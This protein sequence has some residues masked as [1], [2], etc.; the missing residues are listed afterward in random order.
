[1]APTKGTVVSAA[2]APIP[3]HLVGNAFVQQYYHFLHASPNMVY[4]FYRDNSR[5][6]RPSAV[7]GGGMDSVTTIEAINKKI[8]EMDMSTVKMEVDTLHGGLP[9]DAR[10]RHH[11]PRQGPRHR[12]LPR[13]PVPRLLPVLPPRPTDDGD[14]IE[15]GWPW[16]SLV[17]T[18]LCPYLLIWYEMRWM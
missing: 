14:Y 9:L 10:R 1:M 8:M 5:L 4:R 11:R 2:T 18:K 16:P 15:Q 13:R 7:G 6:A 17:L 12:H 3:A